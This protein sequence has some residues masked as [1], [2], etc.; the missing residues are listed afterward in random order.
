LTLEVIITLAVVAGVFALL[1]TTRLDTDVVLVGAMIAVTMAGIVSPAKALSGF[2]SPGV[3]TIA[4]LYL[5]VAG[6]RET[7]AMAW[8]SRWVLGRPAT[9]AVAQAKLMLVTSALSGVINNTP[10]VALFIPVAQEWSARYGFSISKLLM[11]MNH[12]VT[13]AGMCTLIGTSTNLIVSSLLRAEV[14]DA[15]L[16]LFDIAAVGLPLTVIGIVYALLIGTRLLPDRQGPVEQLQNAREYSVEARV[17]PGGPLVNRTI[18]EVG[19]RSMKHAYVLEIERD[20][21]LMTA[22]GPDEVLRPDDSVTFVGVVDAV[23]ELRRI[24]GLSV[25]EDQRFKLNLRNSQRCLVELVL[26]RTSPMVG[27]TVRETHFRSVYRAAILSISRDGARLD[28]KLGD[29]RLRP[30]DTLLVEADHGFVERHRYSRDFLLVSSL[31]DSTPPDFQR[32]PVALAILLAMVVVA[33]MEWLSLFEAS[34]LA[35]G[36][37]VA[38]R[39][40]PLSVGRRSVE[41]PVLVGIA[42]SFALGAALTESGAAD[43]IASAIGV[44]SGADPFWSLA[45]LYLVTVMVTE[46]I[47]NNAAGV[48]MFPIAMA[49]AEGTG[50][51]FMPFVIAIMIGASAGFITPIGYQTNLMIYG[52]GGYRFSDYIRFGL[53]LSV[54]VGVAAVVLIP[55]IWPF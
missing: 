48:M 53:P 55:R 47:T 4:A 37:M 6:L 32:A 30:G 10:V 38:T 25:A 1:S 14:P 12:V 20:G 18:A 40:V 33:A 50:A 17:L 3:M 19:L 35:A 43:M 41:Y 34:F 51:S 46:L 39:C 16:G 24:P 22:V 7:G 54:L 2:A 27:Q 21:R 42:A 15:S 23:N 45:V 8:I 26:S 28:S 29:V 13:L 52:P 11:P 5:V 9:L 31:R 49:T 44:V 36:L